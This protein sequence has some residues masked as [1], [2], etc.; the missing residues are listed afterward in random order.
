MKFIRLEFYGQ[1]S[2]KSEHQDIAKLFQRAMNSMLFER[3]GLS[4]DKQSVLDNHHRG[5]DNHSCEQLSLYR[6]K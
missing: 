1:C 4:S 3:T 5:A 2:Q 6:L